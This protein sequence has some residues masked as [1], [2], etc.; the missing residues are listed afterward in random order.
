MKIESNFHSENYHID[1]FFQELE[2]ESS[3]TEE[4]FKSLARLCQTIVP[5]VSDEQKNKL[6]TR[7][8]KLKDDIFSVKGQLE[9]MML[10]G[11][12]SAELV[13]QI[14]EKKH[15]LETW[16]SSSREVLEDF[17]KGVNLSQL[18]GFLTKFKVRMMKNGL[19]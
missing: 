3:E 8:R 16:I 4:Q 17:N 2:I 19:I 11:R 18:N 14:D 5:Q 7:L 10:R 12:D 13:Q 1:A 6:V 9:E 15:Q